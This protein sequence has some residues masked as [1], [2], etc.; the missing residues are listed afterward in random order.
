MLP[1]GLRRQLVHGPPVFRLGSGFGLGLSRRAL[2]FVR[3]G[4]ILDLLL[5]PTHNLIQLGPQSI[6]LRVETHTNLSSLSHV[7]AGFVNLRPQLV[8][9]LFGQCHLMLVLLLLGLLQ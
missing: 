9:N 4:F 5:T 6:S 7:T 1:A 8:A 3:F 2:Q